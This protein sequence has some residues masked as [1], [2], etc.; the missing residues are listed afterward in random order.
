MKKLLCMI[1]SLS[2]LLLAGC[3]SGG[4][5]IRIGAAGLGGMYYS[6]SNAFANVASEE[7]DKLSFD[8]K[9][10]AGSTANLRLISDQ[11]IEL[12]ISQSDLINDAYHGTGA[13]AGKSYHGY[14]AIA[15][16]FPEA[17]QIVVRADSDIKSLDDLQGKTISIGEEDSGTER[18]AEQILEMSGL[19]SA[20]VKTENL[21]Y[22]DAAEQLAS[23]KID[24]MFCTAGVQTTV[25]EELTRSC[26]IRL[27]DI[28]E[29]C[30]EKLKT[31]YPTY[32][33]YEIPA[34]TYSGQTNA[35]HTLGV[36]AV[37]L[38]SDNLSEDTVKEL[39]ASL[40]RHAKEIQYATSL[41]LQMD[42]ASATQGVSIPF[43]AGAAAYYEEKGLHVS[44]SEQ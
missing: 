14:K 23:G 11:Y 33:D 25:I 4:K 6:F 37:L 10:T 44:S 12:A 43:H 35:I 42:E 30:A 17:C 21:N 7:N 22:T 28:D 1:L 36:N 9:S 41:N 40:F 3:G 26:D 39:T 32:I 20:L 27:L 24:A 18:N 16:L 19:T 2:V 29:K 15:A 13:F 34:N 31:A 5:E 38:A 8:V